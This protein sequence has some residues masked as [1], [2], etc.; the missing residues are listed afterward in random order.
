MERRLQRIDLK[1]EK[2]DVFGRS[3]TPSLP[4]IRHQAVRI[5]GSVRPERGQLTGSIGAILALDWVR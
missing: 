1:L 2:M 4:T 5:G 3:Q